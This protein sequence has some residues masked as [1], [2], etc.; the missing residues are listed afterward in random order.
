MVLAV[1]VVAGVSAAVS[2]SDIHTLVI[3]LGGEGHEIAM[4]F[5]ISIDGCLA[6]SSLT[7]LFSSRYQIKPPWMARLTL[8]IGITMTLITNFAHGLLYGWGAAFLNSWPA[9]ALSLSVELLSWVMGTS[10]ELDT[11]RTVLVVPKP[12]DPN[13]TELTRITEIIANDRTISSAE[14]ARQTGLPYP[15]VL[16]LS[17]EARAMLNG[18]A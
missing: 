3:H 6:S 11:K 1:L 13:D 2:Y 9:V 8:W 18:S 14:V 10:R 17:R 12:Q 5:P 4:I 7:L 15:K 16:K